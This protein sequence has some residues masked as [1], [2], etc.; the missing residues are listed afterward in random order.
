[1]PVAD[2]IDINYGYNGSLQHTTED[3]L[4]KLSPKSLQISGDVILETIRLLNGMGDN[5]PPAPPPQ[6][7]CRR[8]NGPQEKCPRKKW[9]A[10]FG[11]RRRSMAEARKTVLQA[12]LRRWR[13]F[14]AT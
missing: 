10:G 5:P 7:S 2:I 13:Q 11:F 3:T 12:Y 8:E 14:R 1:M 4:D 9:P 6:R